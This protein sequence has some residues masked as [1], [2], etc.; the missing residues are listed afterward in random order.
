MKKTEPYTGIAEAYDYILRHVDYDQWF[1]YI[2]SI[3]LKYISNPGS[4]LELGCGTGKFGAKF[5]AANYRIFGIDRSLEMLRIAKTRA[6]RSFRIICADMRNFYLK[7]SFDFIFSVH[8]TIN[9]QLTTDELRDVFRSVKRVMHNKSIFLFDITTEHNINNYF[10]NKTSFY[11]TRGMNIEWSNRY[12]K[13]KKFIISKFTIRY[14]NGRKF[15][16]EHTQRIYSR[17]EIQTILYEEGFE[18]LDVFSDYTY[19]PPS[20]ET[21]MINFITKKR[22]AL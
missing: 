3:M 12:L 5:S 4:I 22:D 15:T 13:E 21:I 16:E 17:G 7:G 9:Y 19:N 1:K 11:K 18:I 14:D 6:F 2:N 20:D 8:D 10:N